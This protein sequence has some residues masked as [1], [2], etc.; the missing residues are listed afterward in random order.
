MP[1]PP[2]DYVTMLSILLAFLYLTVSTRAFEIS[3]P[4]FV[5]LNEPAT[6]AWTRSERDQGDFVFVLRSLQSG[7]SERLSDVPNN[8][9]SGTISLNFT[10]PGL[11]KVEI[12]RFNTE[13]I[14]I[15]I[16]SPV[17]V[18][19]VDGIL[20]IPYKTETHNPK[21]SASSPPP[22]TAL[23]STASNLTTLHHA[24]SF[25]PFSTP[26]VLSS[27]TVTSSV[28]PTSGYGTILNSSTSTSSSSAA[29]STASQSTSFSSLSTSGAVSDSSSITVTS[30]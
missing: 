11:Y 8:L 24:S 6:A 23:S 1:L 22:D 15:R 28:S 20:N 29:S 14:A 26:E 7:E 4:Y 21:P 27:S 18:L 25:S 9:S 2:N 10:H 19:E 12:G 17:L 30:R 3:V 13:F 5:V 16:S